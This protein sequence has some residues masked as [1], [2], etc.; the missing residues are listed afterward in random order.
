MSLPVWTVRDVCQ[1]L[2]DRE[3]IIVL[4]AYLDA[5]GQKT[6]PIVVVAGFLG[7]PANFEWFEQQW[8]PFLKEFELDHFHATEF[9]AR[10][11]R[12]Y[13]NWT[14]PMCLKAKGDICAILSD[15]HGPPFGVGVAADVRLFQEWRS[16]LNHYY[17]SDPYFYCLDL[18]LSS[19][20]YSTGPNDSGITI[21]CD[22]EK[23]HELLGGDIVKWHEQP[24][25]RPVSVLY[26]PKRRFVPL[27]LADILANDIFR[28]A[29]DAF[30]S[31]GYLLLNERSEWRRDSQ[32]LRDLFIKGF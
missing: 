20:V 30:R 29:S 18:I 26:G 16:S 6:D 31:D 14:E 21:Y 19:L 7:W 22:Q 4:R 28:S 23:E 11:S 1:S 10:K 13:C 27:Q 2:P 3:M 17:P 15:S 8:I 12:P 24:G 5:S 32:P 25:P 9:W